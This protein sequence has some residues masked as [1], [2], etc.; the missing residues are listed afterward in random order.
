MLEQY[1]KELEELKARMLAAEEF[2]IALPIFKEDIIERKLTA[3]DEIIRF[4]SWFKGFYFAWDI[5]RSHYEKGANREVTNYHKP[6]DIHLFSLYINSLSI[7]DSHEEYGL[8]EL[9]EKVDV[10]FYDKLN[11]TFYATDEQI[12]PLL[13]ALVV[14]K[15]QAVVLNK[16]DSRQGKIDSLQEQIDQL[17]Q[18]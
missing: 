4:N 16:A 5:S 12:E 18:N 11:S 8:D 6:H 17:N 7:Y 14:W 9:H 2:S 1:E 3:S 15:E 13:E 10:F